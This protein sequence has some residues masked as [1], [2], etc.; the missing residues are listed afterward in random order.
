MHL[1]QYDCQKKLFKCWVMAWKIQIRRMESLICKFSCLNLKLLVLYC[2]NEIRNIDSFHAIV[3]VKTEEYE[4]HSSNSKNP[5]DILTADLTILLN[6]L[7][8][9]ITNLTLPLTT[10][11]TILTI[12]TTM[13]TIH[14][15]TRFTGPHNSVKIQKLLSVS[16]FVCDFSNL[17]AAYAAKK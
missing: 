9:I 11:L 14:D 5:D 7:T 3:M 10:L 15:H 17:W 13:V 6:I 12:L 4:E 8:T 2:D 1:F 16:L